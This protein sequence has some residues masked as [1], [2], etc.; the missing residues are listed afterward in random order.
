M[1]E[2]ELSSIEIL[3]ED[4]EDWSTMMSAMN[5]A[6]SEMRIDYERGINMNMNA[7]K[8]YKKRLENSTSMNNKIDVDSNNNA[9]NTSNNNL[10]SIN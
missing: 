1:P 10:I 7:N 5:T 4:R 2:T 9:N 8:L 6:L 3:K